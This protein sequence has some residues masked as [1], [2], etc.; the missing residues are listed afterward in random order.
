M[1]NEEYIISKMDEDYLKMASQAV[2]QAFEVDEGEV[3]GRC[4]TWP[5]VFA[6]QTAYWLINKGMGYSYSKT[7]RMFSR[8]HQGIMHGVGKVTEVLELDAV[9][10]HDNGSWANQIR[11]SKKNFVRF[12]LVYTEVKQKET[13]YVVQPS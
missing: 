3:L 6:R 13:D 2:A 5:L 1:E 11:A 12:Y 8:H 10:K 7:G 4:R 9:N